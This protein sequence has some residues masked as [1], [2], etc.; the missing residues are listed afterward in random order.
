MHLVHNTNTVLVILILGTWTP[1]ALITYYYRTRMFKIK[2]NS[3]D[4]R[5]WD[6]FE[7]VFFLANLQ[8][9]GV[10]SST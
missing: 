1:M 5:I 10:P 9:M 7:S 3:L 2:S 4:A 8:Q 6:T